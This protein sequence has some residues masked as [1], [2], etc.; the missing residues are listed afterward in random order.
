MRT[1]YRDAAADLE[2]DGFVVVLADL[3]RLR[4]PKKLWAS[5][6]ALTV[7]ARQV[8]RI[9]R[10]HPRSTLSVRGSPVALLL[11]SHE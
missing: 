8:P 11:L 3:V 1:V 10:V 7:Q 5:D 9:Q 4:S 2:L 6:V